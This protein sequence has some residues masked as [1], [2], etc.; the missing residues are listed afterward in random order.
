LRE[1]FFT[2]ENPADIRE[3]ENGE[4]Y[5]MP[6]SRHV[7][8]IKD[9]NWKRSSFSLILRKMLSM[10]S[11][12]HPYSAILENANSARASECEIDR[13]SVVAS[14]DQVARESRKDRDCREINPRRDYKLHIANK[15]SLAAR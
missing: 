1:I 8:Y 7:L 5:V 14:A 10:F 3:K 6:D 12:K 15:R 9:R 2:K 13:L 4:R 11:N